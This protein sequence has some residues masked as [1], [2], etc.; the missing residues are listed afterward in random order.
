MSDSP[1]KCPSCGF[2]YDRKH[3]QSWVLLDGGKRV[4]THPWHNP[5]SFSRRNAES[6]SSPTWAME[7]MQ[8]INKLTPDITGKAFDPDWFLLRQ[9]LE[10]FEAAAIR[11]AATQRKGAK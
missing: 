7:T 5:N 6:N 9:R 2:D 3:G 4:C 1:T 11:A 10:E 8:I